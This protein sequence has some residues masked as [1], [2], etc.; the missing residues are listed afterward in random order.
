MRPDSPTQ[1]RLRQESEAL[2]RFRFP[3]ACATL[4]SQRLSIASSLLSQ[5]LWGRWFLRCRWSLGAHV[6]R[7]APREPR[8]PSFRGVCT[9]TSPPPAS[10]LPVN[11]SPPLGTGFALLR[12]ARASAGPDSL[13][14]R[15]GRLRADIRHNAACVCA[16][17]GPR[18]P[19]DSSARLSLADGLGA[20]GG[21]LGRSDYDSAD[22]SLERH[23]STLSDPSGGILDRGMNAPRLGVTYATLGSERRLVPHQRRPRRHI[24]LRLSHYARSRDLRS[25]GTSPGVVRLA[26]HTH[27]V[28]PGFHTCGRAT[29][30]EERRRA[31][32]GSGG[33][34]ITLSKVAPSI[35]CPRSSGYEYTEG[36]DLRDKGA[37]L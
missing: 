5:R 32:C 37:A 2:P 9:A 7:P 21:V 12:L 15:A 19:S 14:V 30:T 8:L 23:T 18:T 24:P 10:C 20:S 6:V 34:R 29:P 16:Q 1:P 4:T 26:D 35:L 22:A 31:A 36:L 25:D 13:V 33:S 28:R 27:T 11:R 17:A 3:D